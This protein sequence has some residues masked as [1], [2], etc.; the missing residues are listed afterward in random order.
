M[1]E[2]RQPTAIDR[3]F[4]RLTGVYGRRFLDLYDGMPMDEVKVAWSRELANYATPKGLQAIRWG[5]NN[6][7]EQPPTAVQF[8]LLCRNAPTVEPPRLKDPA[9]NP[10]R[11]AA[12]L[13]RLQKVRA[14]VLDQHG[15]DDFARLAERAARGERLNPTQRTMLAA[16]RGRRG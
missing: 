9:P 3:I 4:E 8:R 13:A 7:P 6:L 16:A 1:T 10:Q 2:P 11:V 14:E 5:L 15:S 12:E